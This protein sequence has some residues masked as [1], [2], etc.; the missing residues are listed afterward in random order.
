[1]T[2]DLDKTLTTWAALGGDVHRLL[3]GPETDA[4]YDEAAELLEALDRLAERE[5]DGSH[6]VLAA[7]L[8]ER[9][10]AY[11]ARH[12]PIP[13][14]GPGEVL[15][16]LMEQHGLKQ[17]DLADVADQGTISRVLSGKR[18]VGRKL[19]EALG[20]RF[21]VDRSVFL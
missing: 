17:A 21:R 14:A 8:A 13:E 20:R 19:A 15:A 1:M 7:L 9:L 4:E 16:F 12:H 11:D 5:P 3:R 2:L 6:T 18:G 10:A